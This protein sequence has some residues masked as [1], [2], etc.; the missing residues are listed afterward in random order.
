MERANELQIPIRI[1]LKSLIHMTMNRWFKSKNRLHEM[2][3]Y[4]LLQNIIRVSLK[5]KKSKKC[6]RLRMFSLMNYIKKLR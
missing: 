4:D 2:A 3:I 1:L 6:L 5:K